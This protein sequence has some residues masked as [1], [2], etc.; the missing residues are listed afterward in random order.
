MTTTPTT[1][2]DPTPGRYW[3]DLANDTADPYSMIGAAV[4]GLL[5]VLVDHEEAEGKAA[6][7]TAAYDELEAELR[8]VEE[9]ASLRQQVID[10]IVD[11]VKPS[12]SKL[13]DKV[14]SIV[15]EAFRVPEVAPVVEPSAGVPAS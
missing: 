6:A 15:D 11:A 14:R 5:A 12:T 4:T 3:L 10:D 2:A 13:A 8:Q 1:P 7:D 9:R